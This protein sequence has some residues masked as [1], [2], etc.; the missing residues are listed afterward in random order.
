MSTSARATIARALRL[1]AHLSPAHGAGGTREVASRRVPRTP[2][3]TLLVTGAAVTGTGLLV[4]ACSGGSESG[5]V[6]AAP[7]IHRQALRAP[8][9]HVPGSASGD[10]TFNT[11][12]GARVASGARTT[13]MPL[14]PSQSIIYTAN[15][16][17]RAK[18]VTTAASLATNAVMGVGGYVAGE[19]VI[20]PPSGTPGTAQVNLTLKIPVARYPAM[21]TSLKALG[22]PIMF[23]QHATDVTQ[24]VVDVNSRVTSAQAAITQLRTLL[25]RAGTVGDLLAVQDHINTQEANL[26]A[27]LAQQRALAH[28]TSYATVSML[29]LGPH[30][31]IVHHKKSKRHGFVAGLAAGWHALGA[32]VTALLTAIGAALPFAVIVALAGGI[33]VGSRRRN[34]RRRPSAPPPV[35]PSATG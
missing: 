18:D 22:R 17:V 13:S 31:V 1:S 5:G 4:A 6:T 19:Q 10:L 20:I 2:V 15:I 9:A 28:Q 26:E 8:V 30:Q 23:S 25:S 16:T 7:A 34:S 11:A 3:R 24:E 14:P 29:I 35:P 12:A 33:V 21:L 32:A 27:L